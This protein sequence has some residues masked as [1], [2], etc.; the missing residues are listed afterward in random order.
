[1]IRRPAVAGM[2]YPAVEKDLGNLVNALISDSGRTSDDLITGIVSPHA[3][4][5]YSGAVAGAAYAAA[6]DDVK[7]VIV[8][9][10]PHRCPVRGASVYDGEGYLTPLGTVPV[11]REITS[12]LLGAGLI[13]QPAAHQ[14]EHSAEVQVPFIQVKWPDSSV[15]MILQGSSSSGY[16]KQLAEIIAETTGSL[17]RIMI[18]ASSDLS[19]Y[20]SL[21]AAE[22]KDR[23]IIDA[24]KSGKAG[25]METAL[26]NGGEACG[27]GPM[28][29]LMNYAHIMKQNRFG[30]IMYGTSASASGDST[31]V[32]GYF[33]GYCGWE[34]GE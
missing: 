20:H 4:Y 25:N 5:I 32:V 17:D 2:F 19:H 21:D 23:K 13:Y 1:M 16:S 29:T 9:A 6:P 27:I 24:F 22:K 26:M 33:A 10:P 7:T 8:L 34:T 12:A 28:L 14:N 18:V 3:G 11:N 30:E 15:V 31:S